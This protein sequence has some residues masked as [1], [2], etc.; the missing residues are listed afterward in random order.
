MA[1]QGPHRFK[2]QSKLDLFS[3][4]LQ[5][6]RSLSTQ[7]LGAL[8][9]ETCRVPQIKALE[10]ATAEGMLSE[11]TQL[12]E[13]MSAV[14]EEDCR[15]EGKLHLLLEL[16][17][18]LDRRHVGSP[19]SGNLVHR[20]VTGERRRVFA[21]SSLFSPQRKLSRPPCRFG[22]CIA[23][24]APLLSEVDDCEEYGERT[25]ASASAAPSLT[26]EDGPQRV[27]VGLA[28]RPIRASPRSHA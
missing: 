25:G 23:S 11:L 2:L 18:V 7:L 17:T 1:L 5:G 13:T 20:I 24:Y 4:L 28:G 21:A 10:L 19:D 6:C 9:P 3:R 22:G 27:N 26:A 16:I 15:L 12:S 8:Q 14:N